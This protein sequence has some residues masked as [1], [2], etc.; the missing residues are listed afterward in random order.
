MKNFYYF[1][2]RIFIVKSNIVNMSNSAIEIDK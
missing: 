1:F 2:I